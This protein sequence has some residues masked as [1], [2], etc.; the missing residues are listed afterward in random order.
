M[1]TV[2]EEEGASGMV[3]ELLTIVILEA[4]NCA[5]EL[6]SGIS[7]KIVDSRQSIRF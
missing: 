3:V 7:M 2:G 5:M 4:L 6:V 1:D